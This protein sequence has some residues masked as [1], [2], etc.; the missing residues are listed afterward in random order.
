MDE[1]KLTEEQLAEVTDAIVA[2]NKIEAIKI[3]RDATGSDLMTAKGDVEDLIKHFE[4]KNPDWVQP[5][6]GGCL[7]M[8]ILAFLAISA[9]DYGLISSFMKFVYPAGP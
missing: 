3:Y 6:S 7:A 8:L 2:G 9:G 4:E 1:V 5:K